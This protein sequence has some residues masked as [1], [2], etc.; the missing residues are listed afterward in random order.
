MKKI[1]KFF[2]FFGPGLV[3]G[4][5]DD[6]PSG[7]ATYSQVGASSGFSLLWLAP[8]TFPLMSAVQE[9]CARIGLVTGHGLSGVLKKH[10]PVWV[11]YPMAILVLV[12][13]TINI[14]ADIAGMA[15]AA[16]LIIPLPA[17]IWAVLFSGGLMLLM[18]YA[19]YHIIA[20]YLKWFTLA[21]FAYFAV[22]FVIRT[23]W[24][25]VFQHT[26]LPSLKFDHTSITLFVAVLG[27][28][29]SP[30]LFFWQASMEVENKLEQ[31]K[32]KFLRKWVVTKHEIRLMEEDVTLGMFFSNIAMWFIIITTAVTLFA[33]G[34]TNIETAQQAASALK[35]IAGDFAFLLFAFGIVATGF[36]AIPV[37]A[38]SSSYALSEA[39]GWQEG[40][41][42]PFHK[43][44]KFYYVIIFSTVIGVLMNLI[45]LPPI[46]ML[47]YTAVIYGLVSP[48]LILIIL[49]ISNNKK[50]MGRWANGT[51]SNVLGIFTFLLMGFGALFFIS[52]LF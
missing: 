17:F 7:I 51:L 5:S 21:I 47:L 38:G 3:T 39:F 14:G 31:I 36:L 33:S 22:P 32:E 45:G 4:A 41:D 19:P 43:A 18:I 2:S 49:L 28:T 34:I 35:P 9:M 24:V 26:I 40:L 8:L 29:I 11:I 27:T 42:K 25:S 1:K 48:P 10:Y 12:A 30:Y 50:I 6:D 15:A 20:K 13:N 46:K 37:L 52:T 23:D 44:K 16:N